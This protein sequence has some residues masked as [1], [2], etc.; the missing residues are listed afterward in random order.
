MDTERFGSSICREGGRHE[1]AAELIA[2]GQHCPSNASMTVLSLMHH[3]P[4]FT[5]HQ[6]SLPSTELPKVNSSDFIV[7]LATLA[8]DPMKVTSVNA[9]SVRSKLAIS[10]H[11]QRLYSESWKESID[12]SYE[13]RKKWY[14]DFFFLQVKHYSNI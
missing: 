10:P 6:Q 8:A 13:S 5:Q 4:D 14:V 3:H 1:K 2:E 9:F 12:R 7:V 11:L